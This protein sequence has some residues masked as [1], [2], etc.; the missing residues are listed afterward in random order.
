MNTKYSTFVISSKIDLAEKEAVSIK[1]AS[2]FA[3]ML[4][5]QLHQTSAKDG[6]G[7]HNLFQ[8]VAESCYN[9]RLAGDFED[10]ADRIKKTK[11][12]K[13]TEKP[14]LGGQNPASTSNQNGSQ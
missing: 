14:N 4:N 13:L 12:F 10:D 7:V 6:T 5:G 2:T 3:K 8:A 1:D 9:R 11:S